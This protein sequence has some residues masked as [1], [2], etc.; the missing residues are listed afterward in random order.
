MSDEHE[1]RIIRYWLRR[2]AGCVVFLIEN[3]WD[4]PGSCYSFDWHFLRNREG[5]E[6]WLSS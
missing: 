3:S 6:E 5:A 4:W 2:D 1:P